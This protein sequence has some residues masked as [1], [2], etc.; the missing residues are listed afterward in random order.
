MKNICYAEYIPPDYCATQEILLLRQSWN[1]LYS[2]IE[3]YIFGAEGAEN[4]QNE[5]IYISNDIYI[6][7]F[8]DFAPKARKIYIGWYIFFQIYISIYIF[9]NIYIYGMI[10]I[11]LQKIYIKRYMNIV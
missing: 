2:Y 8:G 6:W 1:K 7:D 5:Q 9:Q 11:Y 3:I 10:Y 4:P